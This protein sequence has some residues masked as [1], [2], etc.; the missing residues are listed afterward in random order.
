MK[1]RMFI[2]LF[3]LLVTCWLTGSVMAE[4][5]RVRI[6]LAENNQVAKDDAYWVGQKV[7]LV[8]EVLAETHFSGATRLYL[9]DVSG[10]ILYKP[11]ERAVV[12]SRDINK[13]TYSVQRHELSFYPQRAGTFEI[14]AFTVSF[15]VA[16]VPGAETTE[17]QAKTRAL[18][19]KAVLPA[20]AEKLRSL[21][22]TTDLKV[23][24]TWSPDPAT[25]DA[26]LKAGSAIKRQITFRAS[27]LPG[28]AFPH[29]RL[30]EPEGIKMYRSRAQ[31]N[32]R[33]ARG[34][35]TGERT[36][37]VTYVCQEGGDYLLPAM[38]ITWWDLDQEE[39]KT[40]TLPERRFSVLEQ[41]ASANDS[42]QAD[43]AGG[44]A[45]WKG[46]IGLLAGVASVLLAGGFI[47]SIYRVRILA[48]WAERQRDQ[49]E[50]EAAYFKQIR[51]D[52]TPG[53]MAHAINQWFVRF[54][55]S[56]QPS[57]FGQW[58]MLDP[59]MG[60][61]ADPRIQE[62]WNALQLALVGRKSDWQGG[63]L[64]ALLGEARRGVKGRS[65]SLNQIGGKVK[66]SPLN[67]L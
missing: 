28:M 37:S 44:I 2:R 39:L 45:G 62:Q 57:S 19:I 67:P 43:D 41:P 59:T 22:S 54:P 25:L 61:P 51:E 60:G 31:V 33:L 32:D 16:G 15:G 11:E 42:A 5:E 4:V 9:P 20:G 3:T 50:S 56:G 66:L 48:W 53:E 40:I 17:Y 65:R 7:S 1:N 14:P 21:I 46:W 27:D 26:P 13:V 18:P 34:D 49:R 6:F 47:F 10:A 29:L 64:L 23:T 24:E 36:D 52:L 63:E 38:R 55:V 8:V 35:L 12:L 58:A 30:S